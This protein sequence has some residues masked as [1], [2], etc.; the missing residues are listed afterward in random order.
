[1]PLLIDEIIFLDEALE[2]L[3]FSDVF[4]GRHADKPAGQSRLDQDAD[5]GN[6]ADE[7]L[8][9]RPDPRS[10]IESEDDEA[11]TPEE[12]KRLANGVRRGAVTAGKFS[13]DEA[14]IG[15]QP[16]LDD[17]SRMSW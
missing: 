3:Q 11:F 7:I 17:G 8:V 4:F 12:L 16:A 2:A 14:L 9:D 10:A 15:L 13:C 1:M 5:L 6:V